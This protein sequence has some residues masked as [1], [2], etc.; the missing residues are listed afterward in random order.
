MKIN[1]SE[2]V[3]IDILYSVLA[4]SSSAVC[5]NKSRKSSMKTKA[6]K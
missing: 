6:R 2:S 4:Q 1:R 3:H 5:E